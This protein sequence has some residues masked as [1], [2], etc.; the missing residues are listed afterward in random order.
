MKRFLLIVLVIIIAV[1]TTGFFLPKEKTVTQTLNATIPFDGISRAIVN[2]NQWQNW[3][4]GK[5]LNDSTVSYEGTDITINLLLLNGFKASV[6]DG[7]NLVFIDFQSAATYNAETA[8]TLTSTIS[9]SSNPFLK[10]FQYLSAGSSL[11]KWEN[12]LQILKANFSDIR[13]IYGFD[14]QS[15]KVPNSSY[16][17]AQQ[18][19]DHAPTNEELYRLIDEVKK[20]IAS[21]KGKVMND[22]ILNIVKESDKAYSAMVA[23]ATDRD[24][25][26]KGRF[27]LKQMMLG[28]LVVAKVTGGPAT[29]EKCRQAVQF[30]VND[31]RKVSPAIAF[32]RLISNRLTTDSTQWITTINYPVFQ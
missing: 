12:L 22:P 6:K 16:I 3:W 9:L 17:S 14:I 4:P 18:N 19:Y 27:M 7:S 26:G 30:Y 31:Y 29:I 11:K 23:V 1:F 25:P 8:L 28:N 24:L 13:K 10:V 21:E 20:Y 15:G 32:E 2:K 5:V